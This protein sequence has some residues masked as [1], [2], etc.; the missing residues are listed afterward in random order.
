MG[1]ANERLTRA[2]AG[3]ANERLTRASAELAWMISNNPILNQNLTISNASNS[4]FQ[5]MSP[6]YD[7]F[8]MQTILG[9]NERSLQGNRIGRHSFDGIIN[10]H[11]LQSIVRRTRA[12]DDASF[13]LGSTNGRQLGSSE[14]A[15]YDSQSS[16]QSL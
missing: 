1:L 11:L 10:G 7:N 15:T 13:Q 3:L 5:E 6:Y 9:D 14:E 4:Q 2:S 16:R 8:L 12:S